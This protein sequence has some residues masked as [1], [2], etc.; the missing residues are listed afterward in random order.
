MLTKPRER[1]ERA[2]AEASP[3]MLLR[4]AG[5]M[6]AKSDVSADGTGARALTRQNQ[7]AFHQNWLTIAECGPPGARLRV[8]Q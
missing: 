8:I 2:P 3:S 1:A 5:R 7:F 4:R 6:K